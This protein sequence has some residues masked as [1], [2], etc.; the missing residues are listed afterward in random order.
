MVDIKGSPI[1]LLRGLTSLLGD[2]EYF[3]VGTNH[4]S[5]TMKTGISKLYQKLIPS[6][7]YSKLRQ[8]RQIVVDPDLLQFT[9]P[10]SVPSV[11]SHIQKQISY[12]QFLTWANLQNPNTI[13]SDEVVV[14]QLSI[15][16]DTVNVKD[17]TQWYDINTKTFT[18]GFKEIYHGY[19]TSV[20]NHQSE[21]LEN[22]QQFLINIEVPKYIKNNTVAMM[23]CKDAPTSEIYSEDTIPGLSCSHDARQTWWELLDSTTRAEDGDGNMKSILSSNVVW[24]MIDN[25]LLQHISELQFYR[26]NGIS[27][28]YSNHCWRSTDPS[29]SPQIINIPF[30]TMKPISW[31]NYQI[32][33]ILSYMM[34][35]QEILYKRWVK[36]CFEFNTEG[37]P[38]IIYDQR[39]Y[40]FRVISA[41][42]DVLT[43]RDNHSVSAI[44][45]AEK[46]TLLSNAIKN[47]N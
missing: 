39:S 11:N 24:E 36:G 22:L 17:L 16:L 21:L 28:N 2:Y 4:N 42:Q 31:Y 38:E 27:L 35:E 5:P 33:Q 23:G 13:K 37:L 9:K 29:K 47:S 45:K 7:L 14:G 41:T 18:P 10:Q 25:H 40:Q 6:H 15:I 12:I 1:T 43:Q 19:I 30:P 34:D 8:I 3:L 32:N 46:Q 20:C 44:H 26:I